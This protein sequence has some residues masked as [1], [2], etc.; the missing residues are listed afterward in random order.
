MMPRFVLRFMAYVL[1]SAASLSAETKPAKAPVLWTGEIPHDMGN[2]GLSFDGNEK[3]LVYG[4]ERTG[5]LSSRESPEISSAF[6]LHLSLLDARSGRLILSRDWGT[7]LYKSDLQVTAGGVLVQTG[8]V[9]RMYSS[10]LRQVRGLP[11]PHDPNGSFFASISASGKTIMVSHYFRKDDNYIS[12]IYVLDAATLKVRYSWDQ[13]PPLFHA[14]LSDNKFAESRG[15]VMIVTEF[16]S[17]NPTKVIPVIT[18][19]KPGCAAGVIGPKVI[20]DAWMLQ[21]DCKQVLLWGDPGDEPEPLDA[22]NGSGVTAAPGTACKS[23][24]PAMSA[25]VAIASDNPQFVALTLPD[26]KIKKPL[27][28]ERRTCLDEL[29]I[30]VYDLSLKKTILTLSV[31]PLPTDFALSPDGSMLAVLNGGNVS[32]YSVPVQPQAAR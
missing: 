30:A 27:L 22:F 5:Q 12:H 3:L 11:I 24:S 26:L 1:I 10:D 29:V 31:D 16:G 18:N 19:K 8:G 20:S 6:Q 25:K 23:Y 14:S 2:S 32:V 9:F 13:Y 7:R 21:R 15:G 17:T 28:A 4:V